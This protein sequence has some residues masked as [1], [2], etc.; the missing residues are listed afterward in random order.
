MGILDVCRF[1]SG[2]HCNRHCLRFLSSVQAFAMAFGGNRKLDTEELQIL[3]EDE[4]VRKDLRGRVKKLYGMRFR[5]VSQPEAGSLYYRTRYQIGTYS[6]VFPSLTPL[7]SEGDLLI[8]SIRCTLGFGVARPRFLLY[9]MVYPFGGCC[10]SVAA[11]CCWLSVGTIC[12][13]QMLD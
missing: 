12:G 11:T 8:N 13:Q 6:G 10:I 7:G 2:D 9:W 5:Q 4:V 1:R 3:G